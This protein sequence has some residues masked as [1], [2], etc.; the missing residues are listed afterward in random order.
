MQRISVPFSS[1][2]VAKQWRNV[3]VETF[4]FIP[5]SLHAAFTLVEMLLP[6]NCC[7]FVLS[8]SH[9]LL[10][11]QA[12]LTMRPRLFLIWMVFFCS[13]LP[14]Q[15]MITITGMVTDDSTGN[16]LPYAQ[17]GLTGTN[18]GTVSND[19]GCFTFSFPAGSENDS[20]IVVYLGYNRTTYPLASMAQHSGVI[21]RLRSHPSDLP[22][23]E[24]I[25]LTAE[26]VIRR[27][28]RQIPHNY[29]RDSLIL[30]AFVRSQK[31]MNGRL[32]EFA[33]AMIDNLKTGYGHY[34]A[35]KEKRR[36]QGSNVPSLVRGRAISDTSLV[37]SMGDVGRNAGCLGC[38]FIHDIVEFYHGTVLDEEQFQYYTFRMEE[39]SET[40]GKVYHVWFDQ[41]KGVKK[42]LRK[43][44]MWINAGD[45][46]LLRITQKPSFEGYDTFR[47]ARMRE[48]FFISGSDGWYQEMPGMNQTTSY[49]KRLDGYY[50]HTIRAE[51]HLTF[52]QPATGRKA[53]FYLKNDVV[54]TDA[55]RDPL[56]IR[57]FRGDKKEG[58]HQ[59]WD[60]LATDRDDEFWRSLNYLPVEQILR[61]QIV[62]LKLHRPSP[63]AP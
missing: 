42:M 61:E 40:S 13:G 4:I 17:I 14:A 12:K 24:V 31:Y 18:L 30:T 16:R 38:N 48:P 47:K 41:R 57:A 54:V 52:F 34:P 28:V 60:Q 25:G 20:L 55:E 33:E 3:W 56:K 58:V 37:E 11:L 26:E 46:A 44:E 10:F 62:K 35:N 53:I 27:V 51:S 43:G 29:G 36:M 32:A 6:E 22:E 2:W 9:F 63:D 50:L 19:E 59:R 1:K 5:A 8:N 49:S 21:L 39:I 23:L 15:E 45:F 7:P